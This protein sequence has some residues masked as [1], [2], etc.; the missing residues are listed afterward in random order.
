MYFRRTLFVAALLLGLPL[1]GAAQPAP[2]STASAATDSDPMSDKALELFNEGKKLFRE[3]KYGQAEASFE[4]AW[5]IALKSKGIAANLGECE[6]RLGKHR[7]AAEHLAISLRLAPPADPQRA[8]TEGNF[9][10]VKGK[11]GTLVVQTRPAGAE[12]FVNGKKAGDAPLIDPIFVDPGKVKLRVR[13]EGYTSWEKE[14]EVATGQEGPLE[15]PLEKLAT[16]PTA[17]ATATAT[18]PPP[19]PRSKV[20][21]YVGGGIGVAAAVAGGVLLGVGFAQRADVDERMPRDADGKPLCVRSADAGPELHPDCP[22][23]RDQTA[24]ALTMANAG[25][26]ILIGGGIVIAGA[27]TYFFWAG[28]K[29]ASAKAAMRLTPVAGASGAGLVW[30]GSF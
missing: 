12:I 28:G 5:A 24:T 6:M 10:T 20:P 15:V 13:L 1:T 27:I 29:G 7:E 16:V 8:R 11:I 3:G 30:A 22:A 2:A 19:P 17:T 4:A 21:A 18:A 25:L 14:L 26:P 9:A 23:L